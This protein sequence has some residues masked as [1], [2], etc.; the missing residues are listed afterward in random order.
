MLPRA[1][2][3]QV[4][5]KTWY[6]FYLSIGKT[7][8]FKDGNL[9]LS[10]G[11]LSDEDATGPEYNSSYAA[12]TSAISHLEGMSVV[13]LVNID[14]ILWQYCKADTDC[15]RLCLRNDVS[16]A[17]RAPWPACRI[18]MLQ[19]RPVTIGL[20]TACLFTACSMRRAHVRSGQPMT[21]AKTGSFSWS[22]GRQSRIAG[23][24]CSSRGTSLRG[25]GSAIQACAPPL[26]PFRTRV[27]AF[28]QL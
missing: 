16:H 8:R 7:V 4:R 21:S 23:G 14:P 18:P 5:S 27:V 22:R 19:T 11:H 6:D 2:A 20:F 28:A 1:T 17:A 25:A 12:V 13:S 10:D 3:D 15:T 24:L 9:T 26:S